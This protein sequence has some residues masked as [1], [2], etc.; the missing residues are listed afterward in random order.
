MNNYDV[1]VVNPAGTGSGSG[2][3]ESAALANGLW[4]FSKSL[5]TVIGAAA[6]SL[7]SPRSRILWDT[8]SQSTSTAEGAAVTKAYEKSSN[9][10]PSA[11]ELRNKWLKAQP[12]IAALVDNGLLS[13]EILA[14]GIKRVPRAVQE[15]LSPTVRQYFEMS[16]SYMPVFARMLGEVGNLA[17]QEQLR[18]GLLAPS[19]LD[20]LEGGI[21]GTEKLDRM[22]KLIV[23]MPDVQIAMFRSKNATPEQKIDILNSVL[24]RPL[25]MTAPASPAA[26]S[27]KSAQD[28]LRSLLGGA[29]A[30]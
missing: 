26:N 5:I 19:G 10:L 14:D 12:E 16:E 23:N 3:D 28:K 29:D 8:A 30:R 27:L 1:I 17:E 13:D 4:T 11:I 21:S 22:I 25:S 20:A 2:T 18:A 9:F 6:P 7:V 24:D 15:M